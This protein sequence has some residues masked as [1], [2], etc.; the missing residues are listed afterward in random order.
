MLVTLKSRPKNKTN[1]NN[2][3]PPKQIFHTHIHTYPKKNFLYCPLG[4]EYSIVSKIHSKSF[5]D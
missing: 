3:M 5:T 1:V 4:N 2:G